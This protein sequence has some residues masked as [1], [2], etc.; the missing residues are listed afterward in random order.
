VAVKR[1]RSGGSSRGASKPSRNLS[2]YRQKRDFSKTSEPQGGASKDNIFVVQ[3]HAA[4]RLHYD[5]RLALDGTLKSWAVTRGPSLDPE[6]KRLAVHVED[7][8]MDYARFEGIIP[9]GQYGGGTVMVWD[10]G[11][12]KPIG[13]GRAGYRKGHL[14]FELNGKKMKGRWHLIRMKG[15]GD[16]KREN[17]LLIKGKDDEVGAGDILKKDKSVLSDRSMEQIAS[18]SKGKPA[19]WQSKKKYGSVVKTEAEKLKPQPALKSEPKS[20]AKAGRTALPS[21]IAPELATLVD[22]PPKADDWLHEMKFDGYRLYCA[23]KD[24]KCRLMTRRGLDWTSKFPSLAAQLAKLPVKTAALDGEAVVLDEKGVSDFGRLQEALSDKHTEAVVLFAFDLLHLDGRDLRGLPLLERK[25]ALKALLDRHGIKAKGQPAISYSEHFASD[26]EHFFQ[27]ACH[28]ALEGI[29]SKRA[30]AAYVSGRNTDWVKTKCHQRQE[31]VIGG[32]TNRTNHPGQIGAL[33]LGYYEGEKLKYCGKIGTGMNEK[34]Q[35]SIYKNLQE[36]KIK[37]PP[38]DSKPSD[39]G[40]ACW[41]KPDTV[42]EVEFHSW[43]RDGRLRQG[44]FQGLRLDKQPSTIIRERAVPAE[45]AMA[46]R[47]TAAKGSAKAT[48]D[49][50][51]LKSKTKVAAKPIVSDSPLA[52]LTHPDRVLFADQGLTKRQVGEYYVAVA[53]H[54]L[55]HIVERPLSLVRCPSGQEHCFYQKHP[56]VG[57][58]KSIGRISIKSKG[59][60]EDYLTVKDAAGL[61]ELIQFGSLEIHPWEARI[62]DL[63]NPDR[64]IF[65]LDPDPSVPWARVIDAANRIRDMLESVKLKSFAKTTGGK[66]LHVVIPIAPRH[67]WETVKNFSRTFADYIVREEPDKFTATASKSKRSGRIFIDYLRNERGA[68]A[69][70]PFSTRARKGATV[71]VPLFW[72]EVTPKLNPAS[73]DTDS[74]PVRLRSLRS[75]PWEGFFDI[76]QSLDEIEPQ[77]VEKE[78]SSIKRTAK[79]SR[80]KSRRK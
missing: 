17:W 35:R 37:A 4:R 69:I 48:K 5:F 58:S 36:K 80:T 55:P 26:G 15:R 45:A 1:A 43:T 75:D 16:E 65:D 52:R 57:M 41:V 21:F 13:D 46:T 22:K 24:G 11:T 7:H 2:R 14:E 71:S 3:K 54:I 6:D 66:G 32:Y 38:F 51:N 39:V 67:T 79:A 30:N 60:S 77:T 34:M 29:I 70:A 78:K 19:V 25:A 47:N 33:L 74:V 20:Q 23:I 72:R 63:E 28:M 56:A 10:F 62:D 9:E 59:K 49:V 61:I 44:S 64:I 73:F 12:W 31:F 42:C 76:E 40:R 68:T 8:P 53:D 27:S 50:K 18:P